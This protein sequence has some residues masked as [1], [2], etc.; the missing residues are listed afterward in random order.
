VTAV[1][2]LT[3]TDGMTPDQIAEAFREGRLDAYLRT[4]TR[5]TT[6]ADRVLKTMSGEQIL[7]AIDDGTLDALLASRATS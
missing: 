7:A 4:P 3:S 6:A 5:R 1:E 2:Q